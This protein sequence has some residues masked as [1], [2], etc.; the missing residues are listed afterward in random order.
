MSY[1]NISKANERVR[2]LEA[3]VAK[4][5][6]ENKTLT[7]QLASGQNEFQVA[8][9]EK[10]ELATALQAEKDARAKEVSDLKAEVEAA[11]ESGALEAKRILAASGHPGV[12]GATNPGT[13]ADTKNKL[14]QFRELKGK[15]RTEFW[16]KH[17]DEI[18][19]LGKQ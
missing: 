15:A 12:V 17:K 6:E 1:F 14:E 11:K 8:I 9:K 19:A 18:I 3:S 10:T 13:K 4:L 2:E 7:E 5:T 16:A